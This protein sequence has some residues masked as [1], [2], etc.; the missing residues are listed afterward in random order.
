MTQFGSGYDLLPAQHFNVFHHNQNANQ[1]T[2]SNTIQYHTAQSVGQ[3]DI[4]KA[5]A[6]ASQSAPA[7]RHAMSRSAKA[8]TIALVAQV[9]PMAITTFDANYNINNRKASDDDPFG[10]GDIGGVENP[11]EPNMPLGDVPIL[12]ILLMAI[13]YIAFIH[14]KQKAN[15]NVT[16]L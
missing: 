7:P 4:S 3:T 14:H 9:T 10:G 1:S 5:M 15:N 2:F 11:D 6:M 16:N 12:F 13:G 8:P